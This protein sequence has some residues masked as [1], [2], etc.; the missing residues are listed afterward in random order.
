MN[1]E[2]VITESP[3][4]QLL[5]IDD[6]AQMRAGLEISFLRRGWRVETAA[7]AGE[8]VAKFRLRRHPLVV[9]DIRMPDGDGFAVLL[10]HLWVSG[11]VYEPLHNRG[12]VPVAAAA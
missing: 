4:K 12:R 1:L 3:A 6:D 11:E 10:H 2:K 9:T 7:G 8:A 5:V